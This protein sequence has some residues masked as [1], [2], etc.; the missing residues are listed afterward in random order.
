MKIFGYSLTSN[1]NADGSC[2]RC[3]SCGGF[4]FVNRITSTIEYTTCEAYTHCAKC[5]DAVGF[6]AYGYHDPCFKFHDKS[7]PA[8]KDRII[9]K[10][11]G[12]TTP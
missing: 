6:W 3:P 1:Y 5:G 2:W 10:M 12:L 8:L 4:V 7:L 9:Y 11:K